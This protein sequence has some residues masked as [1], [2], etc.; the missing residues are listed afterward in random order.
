[1][2][3]QI[4]TD[5]NIEAHETLIAHLRSSVESA[6]S[7]FGEHI[8]RVE[9]HLSD[10]NAS[11]S[12]PTDKRCLIEA[13]LEGRQP[14]AVKHEAASLGQAVHGATDKLARSIDGILGRA[15]ERASHA[16]DG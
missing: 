8:T 16:I 13:R 11:K 6:L 1:M 7:R 9:V 2:Q 12:G 14:L 3:I 5:H 15:H 4:N 10:E